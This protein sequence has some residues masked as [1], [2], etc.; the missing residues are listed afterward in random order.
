MTSASGPEK[1]TVEIVRSPRRRTLAI[2]VDAGG[3][4]Q[5]RVPRWAA[6][7]DIEEFVDR[8]RDWIS[9]KVA[10]AQRLPGWQPRWVDGGDWYW[11]GQSLPVRAVR[12]RGSRLAADGIELAVPAAVDEAAWR[13][14]LFAWHR[15]ESAALLTARAQQLFAEHCADHRL[16]VVEF[17]WM[18]VTW[19]TCGG[20]RAADGR[21]DIKL[22]LN[23]WLAALPPE[24]ADSVLLHELAHVE[25]MHHG[26]AFYRRLAKLDPDWRAHD[27]ALK[28]WARL[29]FPV[30]AARNES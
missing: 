19:G 30:T 7:H 12:A 6:R 28:Q 13:R 16:A 14:A 3:A 2:H 17:R 22:R 24:L 29:L 26:P 4:V 18:R 25:H 9:R 20:R 10:E 27:E 1:I 15:R 5:V 21:R 11:Q 8:H 23:P